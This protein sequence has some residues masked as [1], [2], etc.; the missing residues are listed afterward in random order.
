MTLL[1]QPMQSAA[2]LGPREWPADN[3]PVKR[4]WA[5][6]QSG[7]DPEPV[8]APLGGALSRPNEP[9]RAD[10]YREISKVTIPKHDRVSA[11]RAG[12]SPHS[13]HARV[14]RLTAGEPYAVAFGGQGSAW[15]E[16]LEELVSSAG[17]ETD[18]ATLVGEA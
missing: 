8:G 14:D 16:T 10:A 11:D 17:I 1:V 13:T 12:N 9:I 7:I 15:L 3:T 6:I 4:F 18:I 5:A 2:P